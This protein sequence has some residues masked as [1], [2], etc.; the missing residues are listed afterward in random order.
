VWIVVGLAG[1]LDQ[2]DD[3]CEDCEEP[4]RVVVT[5]TT[6]TILE[7]VGFAEH[8]AVPLRTDMFDAV[9]EALLGNPSITLLEVAGHVDPSEPGGDRLAL[10]RAQS[11]VDALVDR[12]VPAHAVVARAAVEPDEPL[13]VADTPQRREANRRIDFLIVERA[14]D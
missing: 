6:I 5:D 12:G 2:I 1:C 8:S 3:G 14:A 7:R 11:A 4:G 10:A 9:A 13:V